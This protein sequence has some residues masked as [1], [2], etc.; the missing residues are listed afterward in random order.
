LRASA[1]NAHANGVAVAWALPD[2]LPAGEFDVVVANILTNPLIVLA[3]AIAMRVR[4][5]GR[6]ALTGI[7]SEQA[8]SVA[9]AYGPW[10]TLAPWRRSEGW[11]LLE[12][13]RRR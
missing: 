13:E 9:A 5:G 10:F 3:P 2:D 7:L 12:G 4:V 11:I 1:D 6:L 8:Q